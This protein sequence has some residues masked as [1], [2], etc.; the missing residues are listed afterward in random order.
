MKGAGHTSLSGPPLLFIFRY[1]TSTAASADSQPWPHQPLPPVPSPSRSPFLLSPPFSPSPPLCSLAS[2]I[3]KG[4]PPSFMLL[5][6]DLARALRKK[7]LLLRGKLP[8]TGVMQRHAAVLLDAPHRGPVDRLDLFAFA[9]HTM[10]CLER[11]C[12]EADIGLLTMQADR[13]TT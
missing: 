12:K 1:L 3:R 9:V 4:D 5:A 8:G 11:Q 7:H 13:Q 10:K 2:G 6:D